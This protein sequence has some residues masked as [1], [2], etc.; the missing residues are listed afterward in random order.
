MK[1]AIPKYNQ[2]ESF[3]DT[4]SELS[5]KECSEDFVDVKGQE[6]AKRA[7]VIAAAG[8]HGVLMIGGPSSGKT[9]NSL[10]SRVTGSPSRYSW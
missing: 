7:L 3:D 4:K 5:D 2:C 1:K 10:T 9:I 8:G 6:A